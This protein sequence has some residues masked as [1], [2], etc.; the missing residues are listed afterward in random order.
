MGAE[1][2]N[3]RLAGKTTREEGAARRDFCRG[4][5]QDPQVFGSPRFLFG[6]LTARR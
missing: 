3:G 2:H 4:S 1:G 5:S 6:F